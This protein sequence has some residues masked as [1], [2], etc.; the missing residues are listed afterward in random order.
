MEA[1][2]KTTEALERENQALREALEKAERA[3]E[4]KSRFLSSKSEAKRS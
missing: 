4:A 2:E 3:N 1:R